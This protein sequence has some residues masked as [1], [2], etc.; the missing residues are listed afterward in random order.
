MVPGSSAARE[1]D[2]ADDQFPFAPIVVNAVGTEPTSVVDV[3][4]DPLVNE[5]ATLPAVSR[6]RMPALPSLLK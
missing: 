2:L 3:I 6:H 4:D 1:P 5:T